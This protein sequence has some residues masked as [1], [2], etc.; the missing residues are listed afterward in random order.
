MTDRVGPWCAATSG[1]TPLFTRLPHSSPF[2]HALLQHWVVKQLSSP[3]YWQILCHC[4]SCWGKSKVHLV[5]EEWFMK[6]YVKAEFSPWP[7]ATNLKW[8]KGQ[9]M[10]ALQHYF[11]YF[12][13]MKNL[14][15][16]MNASKCFFLSHYHQ[17]LVCSLSIR[18]GMV[19][20]LSPLNIN[21]W[22]P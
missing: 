10:L 14:G 5:L 6:L 2:V 16:G 11:K 9:L 1:L 19:N 13:L 3:K 18:N 17:M 12:R 21:D 4:K 22:I 20:P 8:L 15:L 7:P